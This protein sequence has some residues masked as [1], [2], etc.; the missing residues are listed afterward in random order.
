MNEGPTAEDIELLLSTPE[1]RKTLEELKRMRTDSGGAQPMTVDPEFVPDIPD[2]I[3]E[4]GYDPKIF[5]D[6]FDTI[7]EVGYDPDV[8]QIDIGA[9][10]Y[11]PGVNVPMDQS[12]TPEKM[13]RQRMLAQLMANQQTRIS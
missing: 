2:S 7:D 10:Q 13:K 1:G 8:D 3:D 11:I 12:M 9:S 6:T 4:V 5:S